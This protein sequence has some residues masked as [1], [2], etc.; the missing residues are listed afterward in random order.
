MSKHQ[1]FFVHGMGRFGDD[2]ADGLIAGFKRLFGRYERVR[3]QKFV[4]FFE[5][6]SIRYDQVFEAWRQQWAADAKGT[7]QALVAGGLTQTLANKLLA[8]AAQP[9]GDGFLRTHAL[10]VLAYRFNEQIRSEVQQSVRDQINAVLK[11]LPKGPPIHVNF[12]AH[13]LGTAVLYETYHGL[14]T[15]DGADGSAFP[16]AVLPDN[17]FMLANV[18]A[19]LWSRGGPS[20]YPAT[21][22]PNL[23][24]TVGWCLH[25]A[26]FGHAL[27]PVAQL[28]PFS[29]PASW[30]KVHAPREEV[31]AD[32]ALRAQDIQDENVHA[33]E[34]Y[35]GH[36]AVHVHMLRQ[37][38]SPR[39][40]GADELKE[41]LA[42][43][44]S[45]TLVADALASARKRLRAALAQSAGDWAARLAVLQ[46]VREI[47]AT[48]KLK[49]G[50]Q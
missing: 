3:Q 10:D 19:P 11:T 34:H 26:N 42:E 41:A 46:A 28:G 47:A 17:V 6:R 37:L 8:A 22:A 50:E 33:F 12:V 1:I 21:M 15:Q 38:T 49:G 32:V 4:D 30:F 43:W 27:D 5:F 18:A 25:L 31:Y 23:S 40:I 20:P 14:L 2:W 24:E 13:S 29:P 35:L 48:S 16:N 7:S 44:R 45:K 39:L 9:A 36:P